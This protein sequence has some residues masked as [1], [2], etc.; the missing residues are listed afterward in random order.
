MHDKRWGRSG[1]EARATNGVPAG[2]AVVAGVG[3]YVLWEYMYAPSDNG[4]SARKEMSYS[5]GVL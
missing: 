5:I 4:K 2:A 3:F 1:E